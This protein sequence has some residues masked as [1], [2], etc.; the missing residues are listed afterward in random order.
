MN[1]PNMSPTWEAQN[2]PPATNV[3]IVHINRQAQTERQV[4]LLLAIVGNVS[5]FL[6]PVRAGE[7]TVS[8]IK[9]SLDSETFSSASATFIRTCNRLDGILDD[10]ARWTTEEADSLEKVVHESAVAQRDALQAQAAEC[11]NRSRPS[12]ALNLKIS[13]TQAGKTLCYVGNLDD[14]AGCVYGMG[15]NLKEA[16]EDFDNQFSGTD[17]KGKKRK[18]NDEEQDSAQA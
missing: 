7:S 13:H 12:R 15:S 11:K 10:E 3:R 17:K 6:L 8:A 5:Q 9:E 18:T 16:M 2:E 14:A 1:D 4:A